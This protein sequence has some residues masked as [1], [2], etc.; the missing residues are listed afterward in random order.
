M[1]AKTASITNNVGRVKYFVM[2]Y[3]GVK[4]NKDGSLAAECASFRN[5]AALKAF[6]DGLT[7]QGYTFN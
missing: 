2:Y 4:T 3:D 5:K 6:A 7:K 1:K